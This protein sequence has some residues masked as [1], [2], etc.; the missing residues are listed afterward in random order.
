MRNLFWF[1]G[2][3]NCLDSNL[4]EFPL[5]ATGWYQIKRCHEVN[6]ANFSDFLDEGMSWIFYKLWFSRLAWISR[7]A[8]F[9]SVIVHDHCAEM[10]TKT[11]SWWIYWLGNTWYLNIV[12]AWS[13]LSGMAQYYYFTGTGVQLS[14]KWLH[15]LF[16]CLV[17]R[18]KPTT[19][20]RIV[21]NHW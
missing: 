20:V 12:K 1:L 15:W 17:Y 7:K 5:S 18:S 3:K 2:N 19:M 14:V 9:R 10:I 4:C 8:V 11:R 6:S 16:Y 13:S 21:K